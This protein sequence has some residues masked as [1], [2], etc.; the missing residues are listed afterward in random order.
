MNGKTYII[1]AAIIG[2]SILLAHPAVCA[3]LLSAGDTLPGTLLPAP[4]KQDG[5]Y[6]GVTGDDPFPIRDI[7]ADAV[8]IEYFSMYCPH[9]QADAPD[10]VILY[11]LIEADEELSG[12]LKF[13]GVGIKNS[14][15][16]VD[17]FRDEYDIPF[18]MFSDKTGAFM[19]DAGIRGTPTYM[20]VARDGSGEMIVLFTQVGKIEDT[21]DFLE[22]LKSHL[23][24]R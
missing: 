6:L 17:Y 12:S 3:E 5:R 18:P 20:L 13:I 10:T 11:G 4:D 15:Y 22:V 9:C 21:A 19:N 1:A 23:V 8:L 2:L 14:D 16:E 7:D 24:D